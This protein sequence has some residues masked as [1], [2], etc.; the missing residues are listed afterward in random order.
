M[1]KVLLIFLFIISIILPLIY[2]SQNKELFLVYDDSYITLTFAKNLFQYKGLTFDGR[3]F[4]EGATS[5][6]H[7]FLISFFN[8]FFH[9]LPLSNILIGIFSYFLL[10][11]LTYK[12]YKLIFNEKIALISSFLTATTGLIIF[13]A[14]S[15]LETILFID[16]ILLT[17]YF[18]EKKNP[19]FGI[20]L[21]LAIY[22]RPE[23][24]FL[25]VALFVYLIFKRIKL[26][27]LFPFAITFLIL[28]PFFISNY[29]NTHSFL[30]QTGIAKAHF[31]DEINIP[32]KAKFQLFSDGLK[33]FYY[34]LLYPFSF[35]FFI[36]LPFAK[37]LYEK[38]YYLI[39]IFLF[40]LGYFILFPGSTGHYWCRYQHIFYP[41]IIGV[42]SLGIEN[43]YKKKIFYFLLSLII[44]N[45]ILSVIDWYQ[46]YNDSILAT[47][48][49]LYDMSNYFKEKTEKD[50]V[51][52]TH[53]VG[54][55][56]YF[57]E[58][59][60][61]DL[62]G[63]TNPEM[64][65]FYKNIKRNERD[66]KDYVIKNANYLVMFDFFKIFLNFSPKEDT[67]FIYLG[68]TKPLFGLNQY[69]EVYGILK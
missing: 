31:F 68:R 53:D 69:Y 37:R 29:K 44:I 30:P 32:L 56:K 7:I 50:A 66:I 43:F 58:R 26:K 5:P 54:A 38:Y 40:Y 21:A 41:F 16:F 45:Q 17:L 24:I 64:R 59:E 33:L 65:R 2:L 60:I 34:Q 1:R 10:I 28:L 51:I 19:L 49:V 42:I 13:D 25:G 52:A 35:L 57:S 39:F 62:V 36:F 9:N 18:F 4:N 48:D 46:R 23:G 15:G 61:L 8:L 47:K 3:Y 14:L 63:L 6:L 55:L 27:E 22:T 67:N 11:F 20:F 12:Y